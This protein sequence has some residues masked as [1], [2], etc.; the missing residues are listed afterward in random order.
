[1]ER[2]VTGKAVD[3]LNN[4]LLLTI[5]NPWLNADFFDSFIR[6]VIKTD[7][8]LNTDLYTS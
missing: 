4:E 7:D 5:T 3:K 1:M 6:R 8:S 2:D